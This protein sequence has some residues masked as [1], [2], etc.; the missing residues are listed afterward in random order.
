MSKPF[1]DRI[2]DTPDG[3]PRFTI[4]LPDGTE[5]KDVKIEMTSNVIQEWDKIGARE[6]NLLFERD[7]D[8]TIRANFV[9][10]A[11]HCRLSNPII[12]GSANYGTTLPANADEG[13]LFFKFE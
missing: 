7:E 9:S 5:M 13:R 6:F 12:L 1:K 11:D 4:T 8:G 3:F 2:V 10:L